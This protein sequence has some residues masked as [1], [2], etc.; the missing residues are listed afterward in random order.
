MSTQ[1][2]AWLRGPLPGIDPYLMP[3]AHAFMQAS[4]DLERAA[5]DLTLEQLWLRPGGAA[6]AGFHLRHIAGVIDRLFTYARGEQLTGQQREA[7]AAEAAPGDPAPDADALVRL[8][9]AAIDGAL[10]ELR[11]TPRETLL[12]PRGV[13]RAQLPSTVLGLLAHAAEHVQRHTGQ[14][15]TTAKIVRGSPEWQR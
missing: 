14:L 4:D 5:C 9:R 2:E 15:I 7:L 1:Q 6:S 3:A 13:G 11:V 10:A 8:A 12:E